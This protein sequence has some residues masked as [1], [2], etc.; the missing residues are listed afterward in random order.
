MKKVI[1]IIVI[2]FLNMPLFSQFEDIFAS[3]GDANKF[4]TEFTD[5]V[6]RGLMCATNAAW[7]TSAKPLKPFRFEINI[8]A[9]G[10]FVPQDRETFKFDPNDYQYLKVDSGPNELPTLMGGDSQTQM[11][12]VIPINNNTEIKVLDFNAPDGIKNQLPL[13]AVPAP[14]LQISMGLPIGTEA[15]IRYSPKLTDDNG[16]FIQL[17]GL[18]IKHSI[19][20]YFPVPTDE[21]GNEKKRYINIA[22]HGAYQNISAGYDDTA[23]DKAVHLDLSTISIQGIVSLDYKL[24]SL[25][26]SVGYTKGFTNLDVLGTYS[27]TYAVRD[28]VT[29]TFIRNETVTIDDPLSLNYDLTGMKYKAGLKL[30]LAFFRIFADYTLQEFPVATVGIGLKF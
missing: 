27:Y 9:S 11:K 8:S 16:G 19:S 4:V 30:K 5:P 18:G 14:S 28:P 25:Y 2:I 17:F 12:I 29:N 23:S 22:V 1:L 24:I 20:Q 15:N 6:F 10:A 26:S 3:Q 7:I 21:N 13:N